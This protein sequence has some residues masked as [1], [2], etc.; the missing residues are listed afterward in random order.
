[1]QVASHWSHRWDWYWSSFCSRPGKMEKCVTVDVEEDILRCIEENPNTNICWIQVAQHMWTAMWRV[2]YAQMLYL[3]HLR[4]VHALRPID[5]HL[6]QEFLQQCG[7]GSFFS[8][9]MFVTYK[10]GFARNGVLN[11]HNLEWHIP[12][13][14]SS[15]QM[16]AAFLNIW[17]G[18]VGDYFIGPF[19]LP[20]ILTDAASWH[21]LQHTLSKFLDIVLQNIWWPGPGFW[22]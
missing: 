8:S 17:A 19:V 10:T 21:F 22:W 16:S 7:E 4:Q 6:C 13:Q 1:M 15:G 3:Y 20:H 14:Y 18:V 12:I 11:S 9:C 2:L 5:F